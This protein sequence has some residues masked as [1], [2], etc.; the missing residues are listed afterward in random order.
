MFEGGDV[1]FP[2]WAG[3]FGKVAAQ[4]TPVVV[5]KASEISGYLVAGVGSDGVSGLDLVA[6]LENMS[7]KLA[8]LEGRLAAL[9]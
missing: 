6:T 8:E 5:T 2:I 9:E 7:E 3:P 4:G 1:S